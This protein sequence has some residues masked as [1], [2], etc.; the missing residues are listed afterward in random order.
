MSYR[1]VWANDRELEDIKP[2]GVTE[3]GNY[4]KMPEPWRE[5]TR[6]WYYHRSGVWILKAIDVRQ[7]TPNHTPALFKPGQKNGFFPIR[8]EWY[9]NGGLGVWLPSHDWRSATEE[10][11]AN[12][13]Y[14]IVHNSEPR[15]FWIGCEHDFREYKTEGMHMHFTKCTICGQEWSYDSSG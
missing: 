1:A 12:G 15:Y 4:N 3:W 9:W 2:N 6:D 10:E 14:H 8:I 13:S 5:V 11:R 7:I